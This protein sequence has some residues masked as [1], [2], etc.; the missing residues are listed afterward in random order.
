MAVTKFQMAINRLLGFTA[1][2]VGRS[3]LTGI[4][5]KILS[6]ITKEIET[7]H[8]SDLKDAVSLAR[9]GAGDG[10]GE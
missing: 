3:R 7:A 2:E 8:D 4:Q 10:E 1:N 9:E 5:S 6:E